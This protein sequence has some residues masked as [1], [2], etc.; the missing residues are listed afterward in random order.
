[1]EKEPILVRYENNNS[2]KWDG[3][4]KVVATETL[5]RTGKRGP[6]GLKR[7][8]VHWLGKGG[9]DCS[10]ELCNTG[11]CRGELYSGGGNLGEKNEC[12]IQ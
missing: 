3:K 7:A 12:L 5:V 2:K 1:M 8:E 6:D 10:V 11:R 9:K 4:E